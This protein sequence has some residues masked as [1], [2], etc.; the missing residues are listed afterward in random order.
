MKQLLSF[1]TPAEA[2][3]LKGLLESRGI[4]CEIRGEGF[5]D[6]LGTLGAGI[7]Y[8]P[9]VWIARDEDLKLALEIVNEPADVPERAWTCAQ[10][11]STNESHLGACQSCGAAREDSGSA[12]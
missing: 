3:L 12:E 7:L 11:S 9:S 4:P 8:S 1:D 2:H 10:C 5:S 6:P